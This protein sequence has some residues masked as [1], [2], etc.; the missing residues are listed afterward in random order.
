MVRAS[1]ILKCLLLFLVAFP[2]G[3][4]NLRYRE[5]IL[6]A[7][8]DAR[9]SAKAAYA[10]T[11]DPE[12]KKLITKLA[13]AK[14]YVMS[15]DDAYCVNNVAARATC[16]GNTFYFCAGIFETYIDLMLAMTL[17]H[18]AAHAIGK[19]NECDAEDLANKI[20]SAEG[21]YNYQYGYR[22]CK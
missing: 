21:K 18:E 7:F 19:C 14:Y 11:K 12:I 2:V 6:T 4:Q 13:K 10:K 16:P 22:E 8:K 9:V 20:Y 1:L 3:A 15:R 17:M 5:K